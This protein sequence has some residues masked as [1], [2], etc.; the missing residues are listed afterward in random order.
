MFSHFVT[1]E[2][3]N[4]YRRPDKTDSQGQAKPPKEASQGCLILLPEC[5]ISHG[6]RPTGAWPPIL[7]AAWN[8]TSAEA[9]PGLPRMGFGAQVSRKSEDFRQLFLWHFAQSDASFT[10]NAALPSWH[11][12]HDWPLFMSAIFGADR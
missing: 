8:H 1:V 10:L 11:D 5:A 3:H 12:P 7:G 6:S 2:F 4:T 9:H